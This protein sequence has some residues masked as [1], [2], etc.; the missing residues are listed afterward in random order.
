MGAGPS[1]NYGAT[2]IAGGLASGTRWTIALGPSEENVTGVLANFTVPAGVYPLAVGPPAGYGVVSIVGPNSP[3]ETSVAVVGNSTFSLS[4]GPLYDLTVN[5]SLSYPGPLVPP[6][7]TV[8]GAS[9]GSP[10]PSAGSLPGHRSTWV[11]DGSLED[12]SVVDDPGHEEYFVSTWIPCVAPCLGTHGVV[13]I[14]PARTGMPLASIPVGSNSLAM[15]Y[16]PTRGEVFAPQFERGEVDVL[17]DVSNSV[18]DQIPVGSSPTGVAYDSARSEVVV[19]NSANG[20]LSI[21][22]DATD[23]VVATV[24]AGCPGGCASL[25]YDPARG[26]VWGL[27]S[28]TASSYLVVFNDTTWNTISTV[29]L[30]SPSSGLAYD[31]AGGA[32]VV[33]VGSNVSFVDDVTDRF[34]LSVGTP[35]PVLAVAYDGPRQEVV[36]DSWATPNLTLVS[37]TNYSVIGTVHLGEFARETAVDPSGGTALALPAYPNDVFLVDLATRTSE[38]TVNTSTSEFGTSLVFPVANGTYTLVLDPIAGFSVDVPSA[39]VTIAGRAATVNVSVEP[40]TFGVE[41][42]LAYPFPP[43][44]GNWSVTLDGMTRSSRGPIDFV[45]PDGTYAYSIHP[46]AGCTSSPRSG[47]LTVN[48]TGLYVDVHLSAVAP[49]SALLAVFYAAEGPLLLLGAVSVGTTAV[50]L[51]GWVRRERRR[52]RDRPPSGAVPPARE[53]ER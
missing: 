5:L 43:F 52:P 20:T 29:P 15:A 53:G 35:G 38:A 13:S 12:V 50:V 42:D 26:E 22:S 8:W 40:V 11:G 45:V 30:P 44:S 34:T 21:I 9:V 17:S 23:Q 25:V 48:G 36:A 47:N 28:W 3:T 31:P 49:R 19:S 33:G 18:V 51:T 7:G 41:F 4:F 16:D 14:L 27:D 6:L 10:N 2:F 39:T 24:A 37:T 46:P 32:L 1:P